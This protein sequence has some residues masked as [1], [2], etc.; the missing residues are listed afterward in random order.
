MKF[1][2]PY[3]ELVF[4]AARS[5]GAGGQHVNRTESAITLRWNIKE[6]F[7]L[8]DSQK[9]KLLSRL[10]SRL[11]KDGEILIRCQEFRSQKQNKKACLDKLLQLIEK[12][13]I[14]P[15]KRIKTK[16][17]KASQQRRIE[18]KKTRSEIKQGRQK[19]RL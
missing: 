1:Q 9:D 6:S 17:S 18:Q 11:T 10:R 15:K 12:S 16:P 13:L 19:V 2:L 7:G 14:D 8:P 3:T 5:S 4:E